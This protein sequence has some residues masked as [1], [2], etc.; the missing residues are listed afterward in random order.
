M[1]NTHTNPLSPYPYAAVESHRDRGNGIQ[2]IITNRTPPVCA[3]HLRAYAP[4]PPT[5]TLV[6][7]NNN[8]IAQI[9]GHAAGKMCVYVCDF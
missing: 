9:T 5:H 2:S 3:S 1:Q 4:L 7:I 8:I 6:Y